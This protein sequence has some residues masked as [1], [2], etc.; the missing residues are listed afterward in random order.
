VLA[1]ERDKAA[2]HKAARELIAY[3]V[4]VRRDLDAARLLAEWAVGSQG[5]KLKKGAVL[6]LQNEKQGTTDE[7]RWTPIQPEY[8][9]N[10]AS[11]ADA[12]MATILAILSSGHLAVLGRFSL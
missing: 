4:F 8:D 3:Y 9:K 1:F 10:L 7:H 11:E 2:S 12:R 6:V 5:R